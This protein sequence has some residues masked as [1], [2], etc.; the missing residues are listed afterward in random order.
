MFQGCFREVLR[1]LQGRMM[2]VPRDLGSFKGIQ[3]KYVFSRMFQRSLQFCFRMY[4]IAASRAEGGL[5]YDN[6]ELLKCQ[7]QFLHFMSDEI[8]QI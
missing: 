8:F 6:I 7:N 1:L 2:G 5:V 4:L 3:R